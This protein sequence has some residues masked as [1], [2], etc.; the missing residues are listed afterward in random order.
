MRCLLLI[1]L[2]FLLSGYHQAAFSQQQSM[3]DILSGFEESSSPSD[4]DQLLDGF[5][6]PT[7]QTD[8]QNVA[9]K[10]VDI[11]TQ[12][13][14]K[15]FD[16]TGFFKLATT[17]N[18]A[19]K[20]P[21]TGDTDHRGLSR[22][23]GESNIKFNLRFSD[24]WKARISAYAKHDISYLIN[25][26]DQYTDDVLECNESENEWHEVYL[27]GTLT[28]QLDIWFGRKII[29]WGTSESFRVVDVIN[30]IDYR[31]FG[32]VD[33]EDLRIPL[34]LTQL[35]Y[36]A[37][38]WKLSGILVHEN[39]KL[40]IAPFGSDYYLGDIPV[41]TAVPANTLKNTLFAAAVT[42]RFNGWDISFHSA[43]YYKDIPHLEM[44]DSANMIL[45]QCKLKMIGSTLAVVYGNWL[46]KS[47]LSGSHGHLFFNMP[48]KN[49]YRIDGMIGFEYSGVKDT[50][51]SFEMM[52]QHVFNHDKKLLYVPDR[53]KK[54]TI[55]SAFR[56]SKTF[57][58]DR[59]SLNTLFIMFGS[60]GQHGMFQR[61]SFQY[62]WNDSINMT[63]GSVFYQTGKSY[64]FQ[65]IQ[66][67][68]RV[69]FD[70]QYSF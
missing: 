68:D 21:E 23:R 48:E 65:T 27:Q 58:N 1:F 30:P 57:F 43:K 29:A 52:N 3:D 13:F 38:Q 49:F 60:V 54:N 25:G 40:K 46:L 14:S 53:M 42:G 6:E 36:Y 41:P 12:S 18:M 51:I 64:L 9:S 26:R 17:V 8:N 4:I 69:F 61:M 16:Y 62:D 31:E 24:T 32:M 50:N 7:D 2:S 35:N 66:D 70:M 34:V 22:F 39:R 47:E 63:F 45:T 33:I 5:D 19:H 20:A 67:N 56:L 10:K 59:L 37:G 44:T 15:T 11:N 28:P 55:Q